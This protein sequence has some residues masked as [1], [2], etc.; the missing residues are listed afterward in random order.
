M[1]RHLVSGRFA[2]LLF[3]TLMALTMSVPMSLVMLLVNGGF[4]LD[5][6]TFA[7]RWIQAAATGFLV[8]LPMSSVAVP[9][10][11]RIVELL[12]GRAID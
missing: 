3:S 7:V 11:R 2:G 5:A 8:A 1:S 4:N 9:R 12:T 10:I 6:A